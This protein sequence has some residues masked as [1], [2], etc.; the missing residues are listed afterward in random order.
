M[1]KLAFALSFISLAVSAQTLEER[2]VDVDQSC[3]K[4]RKMNLLVYKVDKG[5]EAKLAPK[6]ALDISGICRG[7]LK[8][9]TQE[10]EYKISF[11]TTSGQEELN[12]VATIDRIGLWNTEKVKNPDIRFFQPTF[13]EHKNQRITIVNI[14]KEMTVTRG[15][16]T[17]VN[18]KTEDIDLLFIEDSWGITNIAPKKASIIVKT[19]KGTAVLENASCDLTI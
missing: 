13:T 2:T 8:R 19:I 6:A 12:Y 5:C 3:T 17:V 14:N 10:I 1:K 11:N 15:N 16:E 9:K 18:L 4:A 7:T